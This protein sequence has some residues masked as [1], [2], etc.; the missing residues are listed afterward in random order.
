MV[1]LAVVGAALTIA[2]SACS[3]A[4]SPRHEQEPADHQPTAALRVDP[5]AT[6]TASITHVAHRP[7]SITL[8]CLGSAGTVRLA[9]LRNTVVNVWASWCQP[10][11]EEM[12]LLQAAHRRWGASIRVLGVDSRDEPAAAA[13]FLAATGV[14]YAQAVD[15]AGELPGRLGSPGLPV[16]VAV[17]ASGAIVFR[18]AGKLAASDLITIQRRLDR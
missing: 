16:T 5:C 17:D 1:R 18:H 11:R 8:P 3:M 6:R 15:T 13:D 4:D 7:P 12:P 2:A 9:G 10:C 14:T